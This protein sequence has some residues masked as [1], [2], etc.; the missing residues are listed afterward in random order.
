[1][2]FIFEPY[3]LAQKV[4]ELGYHLVIILA[5]TG[6]NHSIGNYVANEVLELII[7]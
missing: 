5:G 1:M 3:Y 2:D 7:K 4:Q 6:L